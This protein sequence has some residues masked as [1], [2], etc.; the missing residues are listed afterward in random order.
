MNSLATLLASIYF[1]GSAVCVANGDIFWM[2]FFGCSGALA[3]GLS[4]FFAWVEGK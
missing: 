4:I 1:M 2:K 3:Y